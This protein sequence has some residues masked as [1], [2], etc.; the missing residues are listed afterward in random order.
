MC[1]NTSLRKKKKKNSS[2]GFHFGGEETP[3]RTPQKRGENIKVIKKVKNN[4]KK[5]RTKNKSK[6]EGIQNTKTIKNLRCCDQTRSDLRTV[7]F[8]FFF[9]SRNVKLPMAVVRASIEAA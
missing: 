2:A 6:M 9:L 4:H 3:P 1:S 5:A 7:L 8:I